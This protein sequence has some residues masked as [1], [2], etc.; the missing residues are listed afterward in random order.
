MKKLAILVLVGITLTLAGIPSLAATPKQTSGL[1]EGID[2]EFN[3]YDQGFVLCE[4]LSMRES[5]YTASVLLD[6]L[7]YGTY[8]TILEEDGSWYDVVYRNEAGQLFG[9]WVRKE[10]VLVNPECFTPDGET[11]VYAM[12][13]EGSKRVGLIEGGTPYPI[14]GEVGGFLAISLRGASGFVAKPQL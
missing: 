14:I 7:E 2:E 13:V 3:G 9:G 4:S 11:P 12:P 10:Y 8:C 5:P 6:T 1:F